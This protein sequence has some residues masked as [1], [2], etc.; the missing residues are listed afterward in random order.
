MTA[1]PQDRAGDMAYQSRGSLP[2][3]KPGFYV[4]SGNSSEFRD[5]VTT[6]ATTTERSGEHSHQIRKSRKY[7][8]SFCTKQ[9]S[10]S[11]NL[12]L[13]E[14]MH[15]KK[16]QSRRH[17][18]RSS[19]ITGNSFCR[20][21]RLISWMRHHYL[22]KFKVISGASKRCQPRHVDKQKA[23]DTNNVLL[24]TSNLATSA[25][26]HRVTKHGFKCS[27]CCKEFISSSRCQKHQQRHFPFG[28]KRL[29]DVLKKRAER[30]QWFKKT[31]QGKNSCKWI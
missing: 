7:R 20:R 15:R 28:K 29:P 24:G 1:G 2:Q 19:A 4:Q 5:V 14:L 6:V 8:C 11:Y 16:N 18:Y 22:C 9:F 10:M 13:H 26:N 3:E 30:L 31:S 12:R 25:E 21:K 27:T 17:F 23:G